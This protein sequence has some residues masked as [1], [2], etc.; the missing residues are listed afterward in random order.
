M[1]GGLDARELEICSHAGSGQHLGGV[2][3][4]QKIHVR[5]NKLFVW[6][7][8]THRFG[9]NKGIKNVPFLAAKNDVFSEP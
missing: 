5:S 7:S 1:H 3:V 8:T 9:V 6:G 4:T 2:G